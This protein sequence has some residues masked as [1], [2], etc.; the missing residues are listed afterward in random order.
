MSARPPDAG[1]QTLLPPGERTA[2]SETVPPLSYLWTSFEHLALMPEKDTDISK[3][4]LFMFKIM[5]NDTQFLA[6]QS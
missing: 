1:A 5:K 4:L 6:S 2:N 3:G